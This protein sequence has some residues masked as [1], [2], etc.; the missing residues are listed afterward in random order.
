MRDH[1]LLPGRLAGSSPT[2]Y[3]IPHG[4]NDALQDRLEKG[5]LFTYDVLGST[6]AMGSHQGRQQNFCGNMRRQDG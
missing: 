4:S 6:A 3:L 5:L 2:K 1:R